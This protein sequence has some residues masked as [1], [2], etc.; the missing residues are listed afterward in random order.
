MD[1]YTLW[2][3][4][5]QVRDT[6]GG[7]A[8]WLTW[9]MDLGSGEIRALTWDQVDLEGERLCLRGEELPMPR[10]LCRLLRERRE[11]E[12]A[13]RFLLTDPKGDPLDPPGL[14]R[15]VSALLRR[16]GLEGMT[17]RSFRRFLREDQEAALLRL[18]EQR[19]SIT[20]GDAAALLGISHGQAGRAL[21]SLAL[22]GRLER[23]G[24][25]YYGAVLPPEERREALYRYLDQ[26]GFAY[27]QD[28]ARLLGLEERQCG[29]WLRRLVEEGVLE[30][31]ERKY[32]LAEKD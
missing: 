26:A 2:Q 1:D 6:P 10:S 11:R 21:G 12:G 31:R 30:L 29:R 8:L 9:Q 7:L 17:L 27:R 23:V 3:L 32:F 16:H 4:L 25:R 22:R 19:R 24:N 13:G 5:Q 14:S 18:I 20:R 15:M 28:L